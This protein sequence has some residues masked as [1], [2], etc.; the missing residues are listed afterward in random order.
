M[1]TRRPDPDL[2]DE[3]Q[4]GGEARAAGASGPGGRD[5]APPDEGPHGDTDMQ[6]DLEELRKH[7]GSADGAGGGKDDADRDDVEG[8]SPA[9]GRSTT[10]G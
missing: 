3:E 8:T 5:D 7:A 10:D 2:D 9:E 4:N 1:A 6:R